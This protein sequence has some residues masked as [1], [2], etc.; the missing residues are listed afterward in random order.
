MCDA[1]LEELAAMKRPT[2]IRLPAAL[3]AAAVLYGLRVVAAPAVPSACDGYAASL[4]ERVDPHRAS[5]IAAPGSAS[6]NGDTIVLATA[7]SDGNMVSWVSSN[8]EEF[9]SGLTVP[10]YGF[11]LHD[12]GA[13]F[14]LDPDSPNAIA[15][16][17]RP[18]NTLAAGFVMREGAPFM[19][20][21]LMGGDMQ[22]QGHVQA[23]LNVIDLGA[24]LQ[25]ASDMAR[26]HHSQVS[27]V[28]ALE[29]PLYDL[30]GAALAAMGHEVHAVDG[31]SM[32][33]FQSIMVQPAVDSGTQ[34]QQ[35]RVYRA[36][37]DHR[38]D[39]Q[40]VGW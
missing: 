35:P 38:K 24:N 19:T 10:G 1:D 27:N 33:G 18:Y 32:G 28:L 34:S 11:I 39:G 8:Y 4:C 20:I 25:A 21:T 30:V 31:L 16:H 26:F 29:S 22:A 12:R 9:G 7:D 36:G 13:L 5:M 17:K 40:A 6:G 2:R 14:S 37:S 3:A 23:L 15:P